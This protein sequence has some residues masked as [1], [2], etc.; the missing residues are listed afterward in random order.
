MKLK[1]PGLQ[2]S[3]AWIVGI[4]ASIISI[5]SSYSKTY[6]R[7][8]G[9]LYL[10]RFEGN[11]LTALVIPVVVIGT[12]LIITLQT[13]PY[14][15]KSIR[16]KIFPYKVDKFTKIILVLI[17]ISLGILAIGI[18]IYLEGAKKLKRVTREVPTV[19]E[20]TKKMMQWLDN[21]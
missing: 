8:S 4:I 3:I 5:S 18:P 1:R 12:L 14:I 11:W 13:L 17:V 9:D 20:D 16:H 21:Q 10:Y 7:G 6:I 19:S 15:F 2:L